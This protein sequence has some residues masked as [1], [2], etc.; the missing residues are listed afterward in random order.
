MI[1]T[2]GC[3]RKGHVLAELAAT[4]DGHRVLRMCNH[5]ILHIAANGEVSQQ[6]GSPGPGLWHLCDWETRN[7]AA[8]CPV[9]CAC[10]RVHLVSVA[11]IEA[12]AAAGKRWVVAAPVRPGQPCAM[13]VVTGEQPI[14]LLELA[15]FGSMP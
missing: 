10:R 12:A 8:S 11:D 13:P 9:A 2:V 7:S 4:E 3:R 1:V 14:W 15:R 6:P 5:A